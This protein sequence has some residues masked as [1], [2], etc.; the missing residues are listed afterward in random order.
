MYIL[1]LFWYNNKIPLILNGLF[2]IAKSAI[3]IRFVNYV[4]MFYTSDKDGTNYLC[5]INRLII[6]V[7]SWFWLYL[8]VYDSD[9]DRN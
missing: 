8:V 5:M 4:C 9:T 1:F 2:N 3:N 7:R 6:C